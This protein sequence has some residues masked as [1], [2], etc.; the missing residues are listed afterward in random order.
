MIPAT[1]VAWENPNTLSSW[2]NAKPG[3]NDRE[4]ALSMLSRRSICVLRIPPSITATRTP[5]PRAP[6]SHA[7][8]AWMAWSAHWTG[9]KRS[10]FPIAAAPTPPPGPASPS[11]MP[12]SLGPTQ[13]TSVSRATVPTPGIHDARVAKSVAPEVA[14]V[15]P[16]WGSAPVM[17]P[18]AASTWRARPGGASRH[19]GGSHK[20]P[21]RRSRGGR[22]ARNRASSP[23]SWGR[24]QHRAH[25]R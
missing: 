16:I 21:A 11:G 23:A 8:G 1:C 25:T 14:K 17:A 13:R 5:L 9:K 4:R 10:S 19:R 12:R 24:S 3:T 2:L 7:A 18:P 6:A 20:R 15:T 22:D